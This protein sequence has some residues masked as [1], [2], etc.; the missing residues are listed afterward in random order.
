MSVITKKAL[1]QQ[2]RGSMTVEQAEWFITDIMRVIIK[3]VQR[4]NSVR[5]RGFG[6]FVPMDT[7]EKACNLPNTGLRRIAP[8]RRVKFVAGKFFKNLIQPEVKHDEDKTERD[9]ILRVI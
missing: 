3:E 9:N 2:I 6:M 5:L 7:K 1:A 4:G 8:Q